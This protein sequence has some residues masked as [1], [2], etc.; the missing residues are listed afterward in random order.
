MGRYT[1]KD[2]YV[3][4]IYSGGTVAL[5]A[6]FR[7]LSTSEEAD[8]AEKS[9]GADTHK[10]YIPT[11]TDS[12]AELEF[13]DVTGATGSTEWAAVLPQ[14]S[15]TLIWAPE[16]TTST[17]PKHTVTDVFVTSRKRDMPF[18]DVV[19]VTVAFQFNVAPAQ[20]AYA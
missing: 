14:N 3:Q 17:K 4:W 1:G 13:L 10:S 19:A 16:G 12:S 2:L 6:D 5:N 15:G 11:L 8:S 9:A 7:T 18:D 20:T